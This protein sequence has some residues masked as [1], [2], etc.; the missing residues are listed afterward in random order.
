MM[1]SIEKKQPE[2]LPKGLLENH[3]PVG[4]H[5]SLF[6]PIGLVDRHELILEAFRAYVKLRHEGLFIWMNGAWYFC[7]IE[8]REM[9]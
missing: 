3:N 8:L 7:T 2:D 4:D 5:L 1:N 6:I 9:I